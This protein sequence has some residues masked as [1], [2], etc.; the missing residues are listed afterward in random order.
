MFLI[1]GEI[2]TLWRQKWTIFNECFNL[3]CCVPDDVNGRINTVASIDISVGAYREI[4]KPVR[5]C[6]VRRLKSPNQSI[7]SKIVFEYC[8]L[9]TIVS[10][11]IAHLRMSSS[12]NP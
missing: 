11:E 1:G 2:E 8:R 10:L 12:S 4:A 5:L 3:V 7:G 9:A 6:G